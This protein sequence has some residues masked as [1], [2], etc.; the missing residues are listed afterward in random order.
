MNTRTAASTVPDEERRPERHLSHPKITG[1]NVGLN[2]VC[3]ISLARTEPERRCML[4]LANY[5]N[6]EH[7]CAD[8]LADQL[9]LER[10]Y[11]RAALTDPDVDLTRFV[12][13]VKAFRKTYEEAIPT[14][15]QTE[16]RDTVDNAIRYAMSRRRMVEVVGKNRMGKSECARV[17]WKKNLDRVIWFEC[18]VAQADRDFVYEGVRACGMGTGTAMKPSQLR[19]RMKAIFSP[20]LFD[21]LIVDEG[22]RL[23]PSNIKYQPVRIEFLREIYNDGQGASV[24]ILA[25][26]QHTV[27][28]NRALKENLRWAPGQY[29][30]RV[31]P[32]PLKETM[33]PEDLKAIARHHGA[34]LT[35]GQLDILVQQA[36]ATQGYA[37]LMVNTIDLARFYANEGKITQ[38]HFDRALLQ[39]LIQTGL[40]QAARDKAA[41]GKAA[42]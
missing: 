27:S 23:W 26:P 33:S 24:V 3:R 40:G 2:V 22:H 16:V 11:I 31:V 39:A 42:S 4:W 12:R 7:V 14:M 34:D 9:D 17:H 21:T 8:L 6:V 25:T 38:A 10:A 35:A 32:F 37:G 1:L 13:Q 36:T 20:K 30:G 41:K 19:P 15:V 28:L 5:A 18:P 29:Q